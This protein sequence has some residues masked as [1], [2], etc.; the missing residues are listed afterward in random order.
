LTSEEAHRRL[1]ELT[2]SET[3]ALLLLTALR[4]FYVGLGGFAVATLLSLIGAM[5]LPIGILWILR[6]LEIAAAVAGAIAVA[7]IIHGAGALV[8]ETRIAVQVLQERAQR[9]RQRAYREPIVVTEP[10]DEHNPPQ[11]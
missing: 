6:T 11:Y 10:S 9:V 5:S 8:H 1:R 2:A 7:A 4:S 3:R